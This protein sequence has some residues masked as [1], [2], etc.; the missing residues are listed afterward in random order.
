[1]RAYY[2]LGMSRGIHAEDIED[3]YHGETIRL[4]RE[5]AR[6]SAHEPPAGYDR[7]QSYA[8][9]ADEY[10]GGLLPGIYLQGMGLRKT[11]DC[12]LHLSR[13]EAATGGVF[14][15]DVPVYEQCPE[16]RAS[17]APA[18]AMCTRCGGRGRILTH[19]EFSLCVPPHVADHSRVVL[20]MEDIGLRDVLL[21]VLVRID[22]RLDYEGL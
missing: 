21:E 18:Q 9:A 7:L 3:E 12:E 4:R 11:L 6:A 16:C 19:R 13:Y 20:S 10:F 8:S 1:M 2:V 17:D 15:V 14:P 5:A 22:P